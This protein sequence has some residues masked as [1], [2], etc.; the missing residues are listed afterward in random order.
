MADTAESWPQRSNNVAAT[1]TTSS[2]ESDHGKNSRHQ[3]R[4]VQQRPQQQGVHGRKEALSKEE[5][6]VMEGDQRLGG[7]QPICSDSGLPQGDHR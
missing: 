6:P 3:T 2:D 7:E 1:E 4:L 5:D